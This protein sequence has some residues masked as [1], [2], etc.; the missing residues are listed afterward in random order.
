VIIFENYTKYL[1][2]DKWS[3]DILDKYCRDFDVGIVGF[4]PSQDETYV[5]AQLR[6][7]LLFIDT[8]VKLK[9]STIMIISCLV[10]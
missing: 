1:H 4:M 8:N 9:V 2:M 3:K 5:G 6:N 7:S 10:S